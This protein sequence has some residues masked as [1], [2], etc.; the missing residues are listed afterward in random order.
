MNAASGL[1]QASP[2]RL[3]RSKATPLTLATT[4]TSKTNA[5]V[6]NMTKFHELKSFPMADEREED[7]RAE[8]RD[9]FLAIMISSLGC[10]LSVKNRVK[11]VKGEAHRNV[12]FGTRAIDNMLHEKNY[13]QSP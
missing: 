4:T 10:I 1:G 3:R 2:A 5:R 9:F 6:R 8:V 11:C 12:D 13:M 7:G